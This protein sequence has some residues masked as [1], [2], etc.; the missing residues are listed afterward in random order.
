MKRWKIPVAALA[1]LSMITAACGGDDDSSSSETT[2]APETTAA[3]DGGDDAPETTAAPEPEPA[4]DL[5]GTLSGAG[6]TF[7]NP[8]FQEW[9]FDYNADVQSGVSVDY[10]SIGSGGGIEQFL[11]QTV[12]FGA[13]ERYLRDDALASAL[14]DRGCEAVQFPVLF[15]A[16]VVAFG[17]DQFDGLVLSAEV[18]AAIFQREIT[19]YNDPAIAELNPDRDLPDLEMI[20]VHRSDGSG[21]TSVFTTY[22]EDAAANWT[23]GSGTEVQWPA[24]T[25][26]GQGNEG[27]TVGIE[28]NAGG[29]GYVNQAYALVNSLPTALVINADGNAVEGSLEATTEALDVLEIPDSFQF[30]ILNV[31][32]GGYP[33]V[34]AVWVFVYECGY[35]DNT[36]AMLIDYW[37]WATQSAQAKEL[38]ENLGYPTLGPALQPRVLAAIERI[39]S[40][41]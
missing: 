16:V 4:A 32:G 35:D 14:E 38:A 31:G 26:G 5:A 12:D 21:T 8:V 18:I 40:A 41:E 6:A 15:G 9:A 30:D 2:A 19:N 23:L 27:V 28:Q 10:A 36:A 25:I 22:L 11:L 33:I 17:D 24:G 13:S 1:A 3:A 34:G 29:I 7:P 39:N 20:P 37:T